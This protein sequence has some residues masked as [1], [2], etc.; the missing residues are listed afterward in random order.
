MFDLTELCDLAGVTPRTVRYYIQQGLLPSPGARGPGA[1]YDEEHLQRLHLIRRL[2]KEHLPLAEIRRRL[3]SLDAEGLSAALA[4]PEPP[5][6]SALDYV[7]AVLSR[8]EAPRHESRHESRH[9]PPL[10]APLPAPPLPRAMRMAP[11]GVLMDAAP[12]P[13]PAPPAIPRQTLEP[14]SPPQSTPQRAPERSQWERVALAPDVELHVRR[15]LS[16]G[17]NKLVER[18]VEHARRLFAEDT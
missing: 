11:P 2:Q 18:L 9:A 17:Q 3:E 1:R 4:E 13:P 8:Q 15:P 12:A 14:P 7:R 6:S 10:P 5:H 16:R